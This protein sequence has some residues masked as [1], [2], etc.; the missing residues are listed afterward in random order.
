MKKQTPNLK[1]L[2]V[3]YLAIHHFLPLIKK[4][5]Y[6]SILIRTDNTA[7]MYNINQQ[8]PGRIN[9]TTNRLNRVEMNRKRKKYF[10]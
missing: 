10:R 4:S 1:E 9:I 6:K 8:L 5:K 2:T 7:A 3:I